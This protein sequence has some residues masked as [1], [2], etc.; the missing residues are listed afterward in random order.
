MYPAILAHQ[1]QDIL[2]DYL[3]TT[4]NLSDPQFESALF[5]FLTG[6][7]GLFKGPYV[8]IRLPFRTAA[9]DTAI[10]LDLAPPFAPF[11]H[12]LRAF[13]RLTSRE[14]HQPQNTLV[15]T[16]T[17]SGKTE[18]FLFPILD[19]C[20]RNVGKPGIKAIILY[21]MNALASDQARR[22]AR[23]LWD[24][25]RLKGKVTAGLY[26]GGKGHH[27]TPDRDH[28]VDQREILRSS[29][30]DIL[31]TNY[32]MLDYLLVRP[33]DR[34]LWSRNVEPDALR[35]LVLDELHTYDGAQG[36]D[37]ACLI[38]RLK[39]RLSIPAGSLCAIGTSAT[40]GSKAETGR[41]LAEFATKVFGEVF[42]ETAIVPEDR[43][44]AHEALGEQVDLD[45]SPD[46]S[47]AADL[48]PEAHSS[49]E[50]FLGR[51]C[52]IWFD[53]PGL[54][55]TAIADRLKRHTFLR[56]LLWAI[57]GTP[58]QWDDVEEG[59]AKLEPRFAELSPEI[60]TSAL[61]SF[62]ALVAHAKVAAPRPDDPDFTA[63]FLTSQVQFWIREFRRLVQK[64][65][66]GDPQFAW[67]DE[68]ERDPEL[69]WLPIV[70]CRECGK[71][72]LGSIQKEG[73]S[74]LED[75]ARK[76]GEAFLAKHRSCR[77]LTLGEY[78]EQGLPTYLCPCCLSV[79]FEAVCPCKRQVAIPV[80]VS[81]KLTE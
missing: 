12:Q 75:S 35:Y 31:L 9:P 13:E 58:K 49:P 8:D 27:G 14:G 24:D 72:G 63:P 48:D 77:Y 65:A 26:V 45:R 39:A 43:L 52:E 2:L 42:D 6:P 76:I 68:I 38:R 41:L 62:L 81:D 28:L 25:D 29:P 36:S 80:R 46:A 4:F 73:D 32:K 64:V 16:G 71:N 61:R 10:P 56:S 53:E 57:G 70:F 67:E 11:S 79:G 1:I 5:R 21:P 17:G 18:C 69:H 22:I 15:V 44:S 51:Q 50:V 78:P 20:L 33:D 40:I 3:R 59:V 19:H 60:R 55:P 34:E 47:D 37:V 74:H 23:L 66:A 54:S 30:P 7:E